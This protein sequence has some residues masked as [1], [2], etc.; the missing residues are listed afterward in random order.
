MH[1]TRQ[2]RR[3]G[4]LLL[5]A[6]LLVLAVH[7]W[8]LPLFTRPSLAALLPQDPYIQ[9]YFNQSQA[10]LYTD[11]Y[12]QIR[13]PGD[14][15][16]QVI[17]EAIAAA[18]TSIDV[19]VQEITLPQ[20]ALALRDRAQAG[21]NVRIIVENQYNRVWRPLNEFQ[22]GQMD[23]YQQSKHSEKQQ[24]IDANGNGKI[25]AEEV[26]QRDAIHI[27]TQ[28]QVPLLD[29]TA[30]G[31]KGSGLMHHKFM[32]VDG[33][34]VVLGSANWT[35]SGIHGDFASADSRGNANA[36]L[37]IDSPE[38][39]AVLEEEFDLMWGDGP[40]GKED[41]LFGLQKP[42]RSPRVVNIPG[43]QVTVQFS[44]VSET[45]PWSQSV[46]GLISQTLTQASSS[47]DLALFV[48]SDQGISDRLAQ[49]SQAGVTIQALIDRNFVYRS[50]SEALDMLGTAMPDHRCK[51]EAHNRPWTQPIATVGTPNLP[52]GDKLHHKFALIDNHTVIIGSHN[53]S[54]AA[55]HTNDENL[56]VIRNPTVAAHFRREFDRLAANAEMGFTKD[57]QNRIQRQR[58]Q[59]GG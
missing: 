45:Q 18:T 4:G 31:S 6:I 13:R 16:E 5:G 37:R 25:T 59:C 32:V 15:L 9:V 23:E 40:A 50:Y 33:R 20:I 24:L 29:D 11:P 56:L 51:Y 53:W 42:L 7:H 14:D 49:K 52:E 19:A 47:I 39:A 21:V 54:A 28:G 35:T 10:S 34:T 55:N 22:S 38:L 12:R 27:L 48:F 44:P 26:A 2:Q 17:V 30:D 1:L 43:S 41:S 3:L 58:K 36:L 57:L 46:N 8:L